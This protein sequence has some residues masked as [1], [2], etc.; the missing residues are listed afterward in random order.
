MQQVINASDNPRSSLTRNFPTETNPQKT[1]VSFFV[2]LLAHRQ[3]NHPTDTHNVV[4]P[5]HPVV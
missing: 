1:H 2:H 4:M 5:Y 3:P